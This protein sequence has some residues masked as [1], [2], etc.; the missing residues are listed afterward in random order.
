MFILP[1]GAQIL[2]GKLE[3]IPFLAVLLIWLSL[4]G[5]NSVSSCRNIFI[6]CLDS[7][8]QITHKLITHWAKHLKLSEDLEVKKQ[9]QGCLGNM[10]ECALFPPRQDVAYILSTYRSEAK[11]RQKQ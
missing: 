4:S 9:D 7:S 6:K 8:Q 1:I 5:Y 3:L 2:A 10:L 11:N